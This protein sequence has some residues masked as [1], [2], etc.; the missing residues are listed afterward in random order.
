VDGWPIAVE[1]RNDSW[2]VSETY[3]LL[4][5]HRA[6]LVLHDI[7]KGRNMQPMKGEGLIYIR[8]HGPAGDYRGSYPDDFLQ[9][10]AT[11]IKGWINGGKDVYVYFNNT[12]GNA[13]ENAQSLKRLCEK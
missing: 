4:N 1:F 11:E 6:S 2:Y 7:S 12:A 9:E 3:E 10:K 5:E 13:F 8:F